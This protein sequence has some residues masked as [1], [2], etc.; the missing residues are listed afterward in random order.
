MAPIRPAGFHKVAYCSTWTY[1]LFAL[2][3]FV[4]QRFGRAVVGLH[5]DHM[6]LG[7]EF[8]TY[9]DSRERAVLTNAMM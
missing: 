3:H 1:I 6:A 4:D 9:S 8:K 7:P 2:F 5:Q